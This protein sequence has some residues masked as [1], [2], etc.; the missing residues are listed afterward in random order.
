MVR[1]SE[2]SSLPLYKLYILF[3][4]HFTPERNVQHSRADFFDLKRT[5]KTENPR[6]ETNPR[7]REKL[8]IWK[9]NRGRTSGIKIFVS[10]QQINWQLQPFEKD[11][12]ECLSMEALTEAL[13]EYMFEKLNNSPEREV[14]K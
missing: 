4:L 2:P 6:F 12:K 11:Q 1:E 10:H 3:P 9:N 14:E 13:K 5:E 7:S 8:R